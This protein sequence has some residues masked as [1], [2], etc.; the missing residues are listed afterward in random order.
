MNSGHVI[1]ACTLCR[2]MYMYILYRMHGGGGG[3]VGEGDSWAPD[4]IYK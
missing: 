1:F 4:S 2:I 3:G